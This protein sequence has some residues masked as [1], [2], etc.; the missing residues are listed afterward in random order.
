MRFQHAL[1]VQE[2]HSNLIV[3]SLRFYKNVSPL[4]EL[5]DASNEADAL[6]RDYSVDASLRVDIF[7]A[8]FAAGENIK[9]SGKVLTP[10]EQRP[11]EKVI[12]EGK[13]DGQVL[14]ENEREE[15]LKNLQKA[16]SQTCLEFIVSPMLLS[17]CDPRLILLA[18]NYNKENGVIGF[19]KEELKGV[20]SDV[21]GYNKRSVECSED[22]YDIMFKTPDIFPLFKYAEIPDVLKRA[23]EA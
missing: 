7:N 6:L 16:L 13:R 5:R 2:M 11:V 14:P 19:T 23:I 15:Y 10:K 4:K 9:A 3:E 22:V 1:A 17:S 8:K 18:E 12:L 21:S 20:P